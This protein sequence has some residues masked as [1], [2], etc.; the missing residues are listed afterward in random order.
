MAP[1]PPHHARASVDKISAVPDTPQLGMNNTPLGQTSEPNYRTRSFDPLTLKQ[2]YLEE[3][4]KRLLSHGSKGQYR[5]VS[6]TLAHYADDPWLREKTEREPINEQCEALIIGGGYG[7][8]L[9]AIKMIQAGVTD[10]RIVEKAGDFGGTWYWNRYPGAQCDVESYI[11]MPLCEEIGYMPSEKYA[12][13]EELLA[14]AQRLGRHF[15]LYEKAIFQTEV[16]SLHWD[17]ATTRWIAKTN[18]GDRIRA[19]FVVPVTGLLHRPKMPG[20]PGIE[21]FQGHS[22]HS[23]RWDYDYT[24]GNQKGNL[25]RLANKRVGIIGTGPTAVQIVP[26][27]AKWAKDLYVF[28]RTPS[29]VAERNN[30]LTDPEW[31]SS[32]HPGWQK[33]RMENFQ[34]ILSGGRPD[35]DLVADGLTDLFLRLL[36]RTS[37][38]T[39]LDQEEQAAKRQMEN[40][41]DMEEIRARI[42]RIVH[43]ATTAESLKPYYHRL[44]KRACFHDDYL[45]AF[46]RPNVHLIDTNGAGVAFITPSGVIVGEQSFELDC[47]VFA[48]GFEMGTAWSQRSGIEIHGAQ[49]GQTISSKWGEGAS[50]FHGW[51]TRGFPNCFFVS[52]FQAAITVNFVHITHEQA[53]HLAYVVSTCR[54]RGIQT[55]QPTA[56]AEDTWTEEIVSKGKLQSDFQRECTPGVVHNEKTPIEVAARN[57][58][59]GGGSQAF[60][61]IL[62]RW[63]EDDRLEGLDV[64][65]SVLG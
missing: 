31:Y 22:F 56:T 50:T 26:H 48:S 63:R 6:G 44:C 58:T 17:A 13:A 11:Y 64:E 34:A 43:D 3:R 62:R 52:S 18:R 8:E 5:P 46:N 9:V 12:H 41:K 55:V 24:G 61:N 29:S 54:K 30:T 35:V 36:P 42:D 45:P 23:S 33:Q 60:M 1:S 47:I 4:D 49:A 16:Q 37:T 19:R 28:Q 15:G 21:T 32:L 20:I 57:A 7:G 53:V 59:Y 38:D 10:I 40:F 27:L 2:K 65:Y 51:T 39:E 14:H 25:S